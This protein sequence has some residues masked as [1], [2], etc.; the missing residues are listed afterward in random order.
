MKHIIVPV[1]NEPDPVEVIN[2]FKGVLFVDDYSEILNRYIFL[3][4]GISNIYKKGKGGALLTGIRHIL[5]K[6]KDDD[7]IVFID[8]DGQI[9]LDEIDTFEN[10]ISLYNADGVIGNKRHDFSLIHYNLQRSIV[11]K[12]FNFLVR[13]LFNFNYKDTQC[14][15]KMFRVRALKSVSN[16]LS[17][18]GYGFDVELI[19]ALR[20]KGFKIVDAPIRV[21]RQKNKGS[22][23]LI[24]IYKTFLEILIIYKKYKKGLYL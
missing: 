16:N 24:S 1:F 15:L 19:V 13:K 14:G 9:S 6:A 20:E 22:V 12:T 5:P 7:F 23:S 17:I 21:F 10:I 8:A 2:R 4:N 18:P 11:S 3:K